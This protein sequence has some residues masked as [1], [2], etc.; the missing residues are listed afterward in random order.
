MQK[1]FLSDVCNGITSETWWTRDF[2]D[3]NKNARYEMKAL[4]PENVFDTPKPS[5]LIYRLIQVVNTEEDSITLDFFSGSATT[6]NA[7]MQLN[8]DDDGKRKFIMMQLPE[9]C[10]EDSEAAK[11]ELDFDG[12]VDNIKTD[13]SAED[14]LFQ[15]MLDLGIP[16]SSSIEVK[17]L[18]GKKVYYVQDGYLVACFESV[19][20]K[21]VKAIAQGKP[22]Y[23]VFRDSTLVNFEQIFK[24]YSPS[25]IRK[26]L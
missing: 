1:K 6:A 16:L 8:A 25:T 23:A 19:D 20:D 9:V 7:V 15:V 26:V 14:L 2:A 22:Y 17:D 10:A 24:T 21:T 5:K 18:D 4:F 3:D 13:R 12:L 11:S